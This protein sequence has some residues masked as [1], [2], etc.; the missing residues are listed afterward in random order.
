MLQGYSTVLE[1]EAPP[2]AYSII[3]YL[4]YILTLKMSKSFLDG[5]PLCIQNLLHRRKA[6]DCEY[7]ELRPCHTCRLWQMIT[8]FFP[9][10]YTTETR[11][12]I[13]NMI[14]EFKILLLLVVAV[15]SQ[16]KPAPPV[17]IQNRHISSSSFADYFMKIFCTNCP[18]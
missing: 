1:H 15:E 13:I 6:I 11:S 7:F 4:P 16:L 17:I 5:N 18:L 8:S 10:L 12:Y 14:I 2:S 9:C 3:R